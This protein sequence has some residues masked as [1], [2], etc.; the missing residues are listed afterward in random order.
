MVFRLLR[1]GGGYNVLLRAKRFLLHFLHGAG[2]ALVAIERSD[3]LFNGV[4][5]GNHG[6]NVLVTCLFDFFLCGEIQRVGNG[7][8]QLVVYQ[9]YRHG[10]ILSCNGAR[11]EFH[12]LNGDSYQRQVN[13]F[14][15]KLHLKSFYKLTFGNN[16][17]VYKNVT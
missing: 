12:Q 13:V 10:A 14:H 8:V 5:R 3:G 11:Y 16:F 6:D 2:G 4:A 17:V 7:N 9:L 15:T 1:Q